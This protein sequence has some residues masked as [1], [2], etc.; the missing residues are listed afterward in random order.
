MSPVV[1][2]SRARRPA[3]RL[4]FLAVAVCVGSSCSGGTQTSTSGTTSTIGVTTT[5]TAA[6]STTVDAGPAATDPPGQHSFRVYWMRNCDSPEKATDV[7]TCRVSVGEMRMTG[8]D[9][10]PNAAIDALMAGPNE[11]EKANGL[12]TNI[13]KD[14]K[15]S[16]LEIDPNGVAT[17]DFSRYFETAKTRPQVAQVV[18]TLTQFPQIKSVHFLVDN[19]T[20]GATGVPPITRADLDDMTPTVFVESPTLNATVTPTFKITGTAKTPDGK[21]RYRVAGADGATLVDGSALT[22]AGPNTRGSF[23]QQVKVPPDKPGP[24]LLLTFT[25]EPG[26]PDSDALGVPLVIGS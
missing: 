20:N 22:L 21:F 15:F 18:Y 10:L 19:M 23:V 7:S 2:R 12:S 3:L 5:S 1:L 17:V 14:V 13:R 4:A 6:T 24:A 8:Q 26:A 9:D 25:V 11:A 16:S